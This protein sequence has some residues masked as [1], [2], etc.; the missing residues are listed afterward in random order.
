MRMDHLVR[1]RSDSEL[2]SAREEDAS[3]GV[4]SYQRTES[5]TN[6]RAVDINTASTKRLQVLNGIG[7]V[8]AK[9]IVDG[10]PYRTVSDL[11]TRHI[12][13]RYLFTRISAQFEVARTCRP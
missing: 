10:R 11:E 2:E 9:R 7:V 4:R 12:L 8:Y 1:R 5:L 6:A 3:I 13:P